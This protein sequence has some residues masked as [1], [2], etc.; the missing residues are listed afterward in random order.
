MA[1]IPIEQLEQM[2]RGMREQARWDT[3]RDML[4]GYFFMDP[5]KEKLESLGEHLAKSGYRFMSI[6]KSNN[7]RTYVLHVERVETHTP[8]SLFDRNAELNDL[9]S[10]FGVDSYDGMDVG[11]IELTQ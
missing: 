9:A 1:N 2:F 5:K 11:P 3:S 7:G 8:I 6:Y 10:K 4:W